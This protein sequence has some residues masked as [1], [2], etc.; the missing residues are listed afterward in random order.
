MLGGGPDRPTP[1]V[2]YRVSELE[3]PQCIAPRWGRFF[4]IGI[5]LFKVL[6][7]NCR[8]PRRG[9]HSDDLLFR[10]PIPMPLN[11]ADHARKT[12]CRGRP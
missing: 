4:D 6:V 12:R 1:L 7:D 5:W 8:R 10:D 9:D 11:P 2:T 3:R